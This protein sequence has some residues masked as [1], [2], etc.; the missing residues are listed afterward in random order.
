MTHTHKHTHPNTPAVCITSFLPS[1]ERLWTR[2]LRVPRPDAAD[3]EIFTLLRHGEGSDT[4]YDHHAGKEVV[5]EKS[6]LKVK[7][8][9]LSQP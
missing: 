7:S 2:R 1:T 8:S 9:T 4:Q 3:G 6:K 5:T